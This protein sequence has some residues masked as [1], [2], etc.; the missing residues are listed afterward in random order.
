[1]NSHLMLIGLKCQFLCYGFCHINT[2]LSLQQLWK[3]LTW[4]KGYS[5]HQ[6]CILQCQ[7]VV[8]LP[9]SVK[10]LFKSKDQNAQISSQQTENLHNHLKFVHHLWPMDQQT[11]KQEF[12]RYELSI[13]KFPI[14]LPLWSLLFFFSIFNHY[15]M[16]NGKSWKYFS[17]V[18]A[19]LHKK[20]PY[21]VF[22]EDW[23]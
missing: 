19:G 13:C 14:F 16:K 18:L 2:A 7:R 8:S 5:K 1:M 12:L 20:H 22:Q 6:I 11:D 3:C 21:E 15:G 17:V 4:E 23:Q 9:R 10:C